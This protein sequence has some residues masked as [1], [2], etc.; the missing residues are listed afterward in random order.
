VGTLMPTLM[1]GVI[2]VV[3]GSLLVAVMEVWHKIRG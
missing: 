2:G 1:N 3:A